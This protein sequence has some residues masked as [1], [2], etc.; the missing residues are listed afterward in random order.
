MVFLVEFDHVNSGTISTPEAG[1]PFIE[2]VILSPLARAQQLVAEKKI[3]S[4]GP[5][6]GRIALRFMTEADSL[7]HLDRMITSLP[8]WPHAETHVTTLIALNERREH[9]KQL[10]ERISAVSSRK[11]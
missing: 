7:E 9:V 11:E 4:G 6:V 2:Q 8:I 3:L 10:V 5:V 1:R